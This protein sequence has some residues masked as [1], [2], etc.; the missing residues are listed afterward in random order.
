MVVLLTLTS[1]VQLAPPGIPSAPSG[2][3]AMVAAAAMPA[4]VKSGDATTTMKSIP[5]VS[6]AGSDLLDAR[7][8]KFLTACQASETT[9]AVKKSDALLCNLYRNLTTVLATRKH[10]PVTAQTVQQE[11]LAEPVDPSEADRFCENLSPVLKALRENPQLVAPFN[12]RPLEQEAIC[13]HWCLPVDDVEMVVTLKPIC[14]ALLWGFR[15]LLLPEPDVNPAVQAAEKVIPPL[16]DQGLKLEKVEEKADAATKPAVAVAAAAKPAA[17]QTSAT[18]HVTPST[19]P[20]VAVAPVSTGADKPLESVAKAPAAAA[21]AAPAEEVKE[22]D[23]KK[24]EETKGDDED[25]ESFALEQETKNQQNI[26]DLMGDV[27]ENLDT[28]DEDAGNYG[29]GDSDEDP[30]MDTNVPTAGAGAA[31]KEMAVREQQ[32]QQ[33]PQPEESRFDEVQRQE[34]PVDPFFEESDSNFFS[35]FLF[36]MFAC[37][38][39]YVA[40]HNKSK[41]LALALEGRR[42]ST[43]RGGFS[44]GR[45]H[46]AAYR[47]LDSNLEEAIMSNSAASSRS[48]QQIIY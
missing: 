3:Q 17:Q 13:A 22:D 21:A 19:K 44:K 26:E 48:Q 47:K 41:L 10:D 1:G 12:T 4:P 6:T 33:P 15:R 32:S 42:S 45:K 31:P 36:A 2:E 37:I 14:R 7:Q 27:K 40:Y 18:A 20:V 23:A 38:A 9:T 24:V 5:A 8:L 39:C 34:L 28:P 29:D 11:A 30:S 46:T 16:I 35:Y 25:N 43:G